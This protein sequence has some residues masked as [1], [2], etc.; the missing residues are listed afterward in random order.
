MTKI[1]EDVKLDFQDVLLMPKRSTLDS[2]SKVILDREFKFKHSNIKYEGIPVIVANMDTVGT[3]EMAKALYQYKMSVALHKFYPEDELVDFFTQPESQYTFYTLGITADD[4]EKFRRV[5]QAVEVKGG[6]I[7][8]ICIDVANGYSRKFVDF[9]E[10]FREQYQDSKVV[11]AGNVV[12]PDMVYDLLERGADIVK[13]GIGS[14]AVCT[15]RRITG[16]GYPQLSVVLECAD[17]AHGTNGLICSDGGITCP[18]DFSKAFAAG[19]DFVMSGGVFAGHSQC[20]GKVHGRL[21]NDDM[22]TVTQEKDLANWKSIG[23]ITHK[24][25]KEQVKF[26]VVE[27]LDVKQRRD[28]EPFESL[29]VYPVSF[30]DPSTPPTMKFYGMSSDEAMNKHYGGR[31]NYKASEGK[32]VEVPY[33]GSVEGTVEEILGGLRSTCTYLGAHKLKH[34]SKCSTFIKVNRILNNSLSQYDV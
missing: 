23:Y 28:L 19:A 18:G 24:E 32:V 31:A 5:N 20:G 30:Y 8:Y 6:S 11:M 9:V 34:L 21:R 17:A 1:V 16:V 13:L 26:D 27:N 14:G 2:R 10:K 7:K 22:L 25:T 4:M 12:T 29:T 3:I 15:T 33:K